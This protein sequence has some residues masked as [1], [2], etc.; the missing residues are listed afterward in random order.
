MSPLWPT[1]PINSQL[2][3]FSWAA[4]ANPFVIDP[5]DIPL[6]SIEREVDLPII[7]LPQAPEPELPVQ[8]PDLCRWTLTS[9]RTF[10]LSR[11]LRRS[12]PAPPERVHGLRTQ[13]SMRSLRSVPAMS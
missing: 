5:A 4:G 10:R 13:L 1:I 6:P 9:A 8:C 11:T 3:D 2:K 12:R 7:N